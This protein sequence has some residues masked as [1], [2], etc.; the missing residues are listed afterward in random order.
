M[1]ANK[2]IA[3]VRNYERISFQELKLEENKNRSI[4]VSDDILYISDFTLEKYRCGGDSGNL[5]LATNKHNPLEKYVLKHEYYDCA[6][7][8]YMYSKIGNKLGIKIA[9]VKL[10]VLDNK[11]NVFKSDFVCGIKYF[12]NC[13]HVN[14]DYIE[15]NKNNIDN[16][17]DYFRMYGLG[18]LLEESDG[19]EVVK[20]NKE[21]YRL[22]T[23]DSFTLS[24]FFIHP[25]AYNYNDKNGNN[26][27]KMANKNILLMAKG[28]TEGR[29]NM[30]MF[31][32]QYFLKKYESKYV[33]YYLETFK[34]LEK[35]S[36]KDIEDWINILTWFY[37]DVIG[38]YFKKYLVN[39]KLDVEKFLIRVSKENFDKTFS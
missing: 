6:C 25:L 8:E 4:P 16:W 36:E 5:F 23:T 26:I 31:N 14:F 1:Y 19:I 39:L 30:W 12:E 34:L 2:K 29:M 7:N 32:L 21:I 18:S 28:N 11:K 24:D 10:F 27:R 13:K 3:Y 15:T 17:M 20:H 35:V 9:S 33:A 38:E 37:P 22:D